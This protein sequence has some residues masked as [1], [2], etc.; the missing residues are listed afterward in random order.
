M[1]LSFHEKTSLGNFGGSNIFQAFH[2]KKISGDVETGGIGGTTCPQDFIT[3]QKVSCMFQ[4]VP[5]FKT[6]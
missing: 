3:N 1:L 2:V 5:L 6:G 4:D